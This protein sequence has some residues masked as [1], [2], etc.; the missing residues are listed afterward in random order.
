MKHIVKV[1]TNLKGE[2]KPINIGQ[3]TL[4]IG[5]NGSGKSRI[6]QAIEFALTARVG[7]I[8]GRD[9]VSRPAD[10]LALMP[11]REGTLTSSVVFELCEKLRYR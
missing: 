5:P 11:G 4:L 10:L 7:D 2:S 8:A 9:E 6:W 1:T 3:R